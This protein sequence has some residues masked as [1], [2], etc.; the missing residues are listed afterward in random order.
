[1]PET[2]AVRKHSDAALIGEPFLDGRVF[3]NQGDSRDVLKTL[4]DSSIDSIVTDP[5]YAL[6][7]IVKRFG[8]E[9][10]APA[11]VREG[12]SG[13]Y[14]RA[15]AGFMGQQWDTGEVAFAVEFWAECYRVLKPGGFIAAF[16]GS[17]TSHRMAVAIEDAGF[18]IRDNII[19]MLAS[20]EPWR[21]F[22]ESLDDAQRSALA[23]LLDDVSPSGLLAYCYGTGFPKSHDVSKALDKHLG[24]ARQKVRIPASAVANT[25]ARQ[26]SR[27]YIEAAKANGYHEIDSN[28]PVTVEALMAKGFGTA[29]KPA[30]E[31][32][33]LAR[34]P[35]IGSV[36]EN[37]L[38]H[39]TG[40][41]NVD[42]CR[43][44]GPKPDT[45]RGAGG[46]NGVFGKLGA[47]GRVVDDGRGRH[48][49]NV[50][51]DGSPEVVGCFP[52][53]DGQAGAVG[54][55]QGARG[56]TLVYGEYGP[57]PLAEPRGDAG[58]A[59]RFF[60]SA[61]ADDDDR[62]GSKHPTVKRVELMMWLVRLVTPKGGIVLDPFAGSGSTGEAAWAEGMHC[63]LVEREPKFCDDIRRRL[64]LVFAGPDERKR[65]AVKANG[66]AKELADETDEIPL[67]KALV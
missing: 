33:V 5:P 27:P 50:V 17:R 51:H 49:A 13:A 9:G 61:K 39:G 16:S 6:V 63:V 8:K 67:F 55:A 53:S 3:L 32:I 30:F 45:T 25:K 56:R 60:Y 18:E 21:L 54:P 7:S 11:K 28:D 47:Q 38:E 34:K 40:G 48:P 35:L 59:S 42:G 31:P 2:F 58:S 37:W 65:E 12:G 29:L 64:K 15:S 46:Q 57:R 1:M 43:I 23:R 14:A 10:A 22:L 62:I 36:A 26:D 66:K 44:A 19:D 52:E 4:P 20:D 24:A 41:L